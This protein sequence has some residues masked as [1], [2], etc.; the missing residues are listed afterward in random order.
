MFV[1]AFLH[2]VALDL[3]WFVDIVMNNLFWAFFFAAA[4]YAFYKSPI[5]G[6]V[7][8]TL[9]IWAQVDIANAL[10]WTFG[11]GFLFLPLSVFVATIVVNSFFGKQEWF[12]KNSLLVPLVLIY[13]LFTFINLFVV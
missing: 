10:G 9:L 1:E 13:G 7:M 2:A 5:K 6:G 4:G 12:K 8:L 3:G 11:K